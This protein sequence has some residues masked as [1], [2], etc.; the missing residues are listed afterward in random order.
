MAVTARP[1][2]G[3]LQA[4]RLSVSH[5]G[6]CVERACRAAAARPRSMRLGMPAGA[7]MALQWLWVAMAG[8]QRE[9]RL[10]PGQ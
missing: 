5:K 10:T 2:A 9:T 4:T 6:A 7:A 8:A 3:R 1:T